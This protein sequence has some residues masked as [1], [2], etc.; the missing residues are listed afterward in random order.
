M[1]EH[2]RLWLLWLDEVFDNAL[3]MVGG[4]ALNLARLRR[5]G[6]DVPNGFVISAARDSGADGSDAPCLP[7]EAADAILQFCRRLGAAAVAV[8]SSASVEDS[9]GASFAGQGRSVLNVRTDDDLLAAV[10]TVMDS[11]R[12]PTAQDN[13]ER[14]GV[15]GSRAVMHVI[16]QEMVEAQA[17]GVLFTVNPVTGCLDEMLINATWGRA[18]SLG[19][20]KTWNASSRGKSW[21]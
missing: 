1:S 2:P 6:L 14:M 17:S 11:L 4:K 16:V 18:E 20:P 7:Q 9:P 10:R 12:R 21:S 15:S 13:A 19:L 5:A 8:R 3:A